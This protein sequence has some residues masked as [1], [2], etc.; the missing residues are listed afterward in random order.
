MSDY[1]V[2]VYVDEGFFEYDVPCMQRALGHAEAIMTRGTYRHA[3]EDGSIDLRHVHKVRVVG[4]GL[5]SKYIDR[6]VRT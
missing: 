1:Q 6:F 2:Q 3:R 4:K 5:A